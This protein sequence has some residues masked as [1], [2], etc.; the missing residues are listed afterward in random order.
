M[1]EDKQSTGKTESGGKTRR[2]YS[3]EDKLKAVKLHLEEGYPQRMVREE[4][5]FGEST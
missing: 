2:R 4:M 5:G 1:N 3:F